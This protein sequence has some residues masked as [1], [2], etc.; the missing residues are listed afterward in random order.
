M[1]EKKDIYSL[2]VKGM[3]KLLR[4]FS[5]TLYGRTIF[6]FAYFAPLMSFLVMIGLI[7]ADLI[8]P[9]EQLFYPIVG[10]FFLFIGLFMIG[11]V[12]YYHELRTFAEKTK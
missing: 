10:T 9:E 8:S 3:R 5:N 12:Y 4:S 1:T 2:D 7:V 6:F 11:N